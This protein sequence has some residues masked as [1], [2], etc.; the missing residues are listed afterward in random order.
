MRR[1]HP[2]LLILPLIGLAL[3]AVFL[4]VTTL[5]NAPRPVTPA[6]VTVPP[7]PTVVNVAGEALID[8]TLPTLQG[9]EVSLSDYAGRI[10]F[11]NFWATWCEPCK[12]ELPTFIEFTRTHTAPDDPIILAVNL[13]ESADQV[14]EFAASNAIA[15]DELTVLIDEQGTAADRYGVFNI[16]VT[17]VI[18]QTGVVRYP[19]YGEL[20]LDEIQAYLD[21][22]ARS[23]PEGGP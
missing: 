11:L 2:L 18:D 5:E 13:E 15:I 10:V 14:R 4:F 12:R 17:F 9:D 3:T 8:F 20:T 22:L 21:A 6:P 1:I 23:T 19:S 16:P 7:L